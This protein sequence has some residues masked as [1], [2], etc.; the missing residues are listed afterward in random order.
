MDEQCTE[1]VRSLTDAFVKQYHSIGGKADGII[2][3]A[4][5][6]DG[7][8]EVVGANVNDQVE[9]LRH[10]LENNEH[11]VEKLLKRAKNRGNNEQNIGL[12]YRVSR[13]E[14]KQEGNGNGTRNNQ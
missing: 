1:M 7:W 5:T 11:L 10:Y 6:G 8:Y 3:M 13:T 14:Y 4:K 2:V 9:M 12:Y